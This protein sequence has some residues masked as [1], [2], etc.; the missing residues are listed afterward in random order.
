MTRQEKMYRWYHSFHLN[1]TVILS[2]YI[3]PFISTLYCIAGGSEG[4]QQERLQLKQKRYY[5]ILHRDIVMR[6]CFADVLEVPWGEG[7][8]PTAMARI[9][10]AKFGTWSVIAE[11]ALNARISHHRSFLA[12][13]L[14]LPVNV[15]SMNVWK[16]YWLFTFRI[17]YVQP[18]LLF[19]LSLPAAN[20]PK[21]ETERMR[22]DE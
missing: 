8:R 6:Y 19:T 13:F 7:G 9:Q 4:K 16:K 21:R 18:S 1:T 20:T 10:K 3:V 17:P 14:T 11:K 12:C 15:W 22:K 5:K 2:V